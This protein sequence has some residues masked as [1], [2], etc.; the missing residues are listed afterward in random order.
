M[1]LFLP[2]SLRSWWLSKEVMDLGRLGARSMLQVPRQGVQELGRSVC[3]SEA[4]PNAAALYTEIL[5]LNKQSAF[6]KHDFS[7]TVRVRLIVN[8]K[9]HSWTFGGMTLAW[10][11]QK[12]RVWSKHCRQSSDRAGFSIQT[13]VSCHLHGFPG[14]WG[15][16]ASSSLAATKCVAATRH[17]CSGQ[18]NSL[19]NSTR[20]FPSP[21][22]VL[23]NKRTTIQ[24]DP[25][26]C[27]LCTRWGRIGLT[28]CHSCYA[29][30]SVAACKLRCCA[31]FTTFD[32]ALVMWVIVS[33]WQLWHTFRKEWDSVIPDVGIDLCRATRR[34]MCF[35]RQGNL[36]FTFIALWHALALPSNFEEIEQLAR[37]RGG[38]WNFLNFRLTNI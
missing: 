24:C 13:Y 30:P 15:M 25:F 18:F 23:W 38:R 9:E 3:P 7:I 29:T 37:T 17:G 2:S 26:D 12:P 22:A 11:Y 34:N 31:E 1:F 14:A 6:S 4:W 16:V 32:S 5:L 8:S 21:V 20:C 27:N 35:K 19:D 36:H 33:V 28:G 10:T